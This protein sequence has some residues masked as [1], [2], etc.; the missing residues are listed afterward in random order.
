[1]SVVSKISIYLY[2]IWEPV[3]VKR[4][5]RAGLERRLKAGADVTAAKLHDMT[6]RCSFAARQVPQIFLAQV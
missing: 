6:T 3:K 4:C 2:H 1:M 5:D